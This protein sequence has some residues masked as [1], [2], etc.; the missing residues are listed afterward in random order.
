M[1]T[2]LKRDIANSRDGQWLVFSVISGALIGKV[3]Q[4]LRARGLELHGDGEYT[5]DTPTERFVEAG[6]ALKK[7][8]AGVDR[9][10][11][12]TELEAF[13]IPVAPVYRIGDLF[14]DEHFNARGDFIRVVDDD[15]GELVMP[16]SPFKLSDG[17]ATVRYTGRRLGADNRSV[18][19]DWLGLSEHELQ[20]FAAK[21]II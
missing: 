10:V 19:R 14:D 2:T 4:F 17:A 6:G 5:I 1:I 16:R 8:I 21:G 7:W 3:D 18:Y 11:A 20:E 15:L 13:G 9:S 12:L